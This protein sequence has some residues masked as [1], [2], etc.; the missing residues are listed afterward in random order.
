MPREVLADP[1]VVEVAQAHGRT[2]AQVVLRWHLELGATPIP[3]T[4]SP[5]RMAEN[6]DVFD[7]T[8]TPAEVAAISAVDAGEHRMTD[9][10]EFGH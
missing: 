6:L 10:D 2:P 9:A 5:K 8:L 7:F 4:T 3:K 1:A